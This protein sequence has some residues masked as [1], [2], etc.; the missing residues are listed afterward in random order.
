MSRK[1]IFKEL[2][3]KKFLFIHWTTISGWDFIKELIAIDFHAKNRSKQVWTQ[4]YSIDL[5]I[6]LLDLFNVY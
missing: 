5:F 3:T 2:S 6:K 4:D 1:S